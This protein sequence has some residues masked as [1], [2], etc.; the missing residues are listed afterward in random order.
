MK[1]IKKML[2]N[3]DFF[4]NYDYLFITRDQFGD[5]D[6]VFGVI[7]PAIEGTIKDFA[8]FTG[9]VERVMFGWAPD[10]RHYDAIVAGEDEE[11]CRGGTCG[12]ESDL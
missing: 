10:K 6:E 5:F 3:P 12:S 9:E 2:G 1:A 7:V 11:E 8:A 4:D